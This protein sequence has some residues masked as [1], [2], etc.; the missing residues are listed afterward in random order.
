MSR[1]KNRPRPGFETRKKPANQGTSQGFTP[2]ASGL[3]ATKGSQR[4]F[5]VMMV[6]ATLMILAAVVA[7]VSIPSTPTTTVP[8]AAEPLQYQPVTVTGASLV[9]LPDPTSQTPDPAIGAHA[10]A[11]SGSDFVG[12]PVSVP[13]SGQVNL[14][15]FGAHWCPHCQAELPKV[16]VW[17]T[18]GSFG[19]NVSVTA[20]STG[21][22]S[23]AP[24]FPPSAWFADMGWT[25]PVLVDDADGTAAKAYGLTGYPFLVVLDANGNVV[26][27]AAGEVPLEVLNQMLAS[28]R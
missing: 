15:V 5:I 6:I 8:G 13:I 27:R 7:A 4:R 18:D 26:A 3:T 17:A 28:A 14:L 20:I 24:N 12:T 16:A 22:D 25:Q 11:L 9:A 2:R 23:T 21:T 19:P 10:P 1:P